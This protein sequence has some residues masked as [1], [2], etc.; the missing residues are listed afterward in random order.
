NTYLS[1]FQALGGLG[2]ILGALGLAVILLRS[3]WERRGELALLRALGFWG[4]ALGWLVLAENGFLLILGLGWGTVTAVLS[5]LPPLLSGTGA[6]PW[7]R[8]VV[9]LIV[10][11]V[12][13]LTAGAIAVTRALHAPL[14]PAL[15]QE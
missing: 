9:L 8:L 4:R 12:V 15:R 10:V 5:L 13:G 1:T 2:L 14:L 7:V 6:V 11:L 3:V